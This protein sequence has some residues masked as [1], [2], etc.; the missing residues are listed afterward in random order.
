MRRRCALLLALGLAGC[1]PPPAAPPPDLVRTV[2]VL[3]PANH[4]GDPLLVTGASFLERW[5]L[6]SDRVTVPEVLA[7]EAGVQL[8]RR[9][10]T[11]VP[12]DVVSGATEDRAPESVEAAAA[13]AA[14]ARLPGLALWLDVRRWEPDAP[15]HPAFV[16]VALTASLV[17][18]ASGRVVWR[19]APRPAP[20]ATPGEVELGSAYVTAARKAVAA[21]LAPLGPERR[22][23][24]E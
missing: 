11:V 16:I 18:P 4:T 6:R 7:A 21:L 24:P 23:A 12:A 13:V 10:F 20:V 8:A 14:R 17:D 9:G 19:N 3:P 2:A 22:A 1:T 5:A 15:V